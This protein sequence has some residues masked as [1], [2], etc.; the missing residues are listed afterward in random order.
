MYLS[1]LFYT[2]VKTKMYTISKNTLSN[3]IHLNQTLA[4]HISSK[5]YQIKTDQNFLNDHQGTVLNYMEL[6]VAELD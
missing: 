6:Y 2:S 5:T 1:K 3:Y 4:P